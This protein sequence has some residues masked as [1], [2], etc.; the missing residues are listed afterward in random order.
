[1]KFKI[2][3]DIMN[4]G[5][6]KE[7]EEYCIKGLKEYCYSSDTE[8]NHCKADDIITQLLSGLGFKKL[9]EEYDKIFKWYA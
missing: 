3:L 9:V 7:L 8:G 5:E 6:Y 4:I 2:L 1:M